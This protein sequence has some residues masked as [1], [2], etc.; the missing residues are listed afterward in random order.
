MTT[1]PTDS[2]QQGTPGTVIA[3]WIFV[4]LFPLIGLCIGVDAYTKG[5]KV[6]GRQIMVAG[7]ALSVLWIFIG[8]SLS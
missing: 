2:P 6:E 1:T 8:L 7:A 3:G 5:H 4:V